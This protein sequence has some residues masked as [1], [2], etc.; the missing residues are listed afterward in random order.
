MGGPVE[1]DFGRGYERF[2]NEVI[3][4]HSTWDVYQGFFG[5]KETVETLNK[6]AGFTFWTVQ[7]TMMRDIQIHICRLLDRPEVSGKECLT[8]ERIKS[9]MPSDWSDAEKS[10]L[11]SIADE[12]KKASASIRENRNTRIAHLDLQTAVAE[13]PKG[14]GFTL[15]DI[16]S[17]IELLAKF[18][19]RIERHYGEEYHFTPINPDGPSSIE[20]HLRAGLRFYEIQ[21]A[22]ALQYITG[23]QALQKLQERP[24]RPKAEKG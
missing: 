20:C 4:L 19:N 9:L 5:S 11:H 21:K 3:E 8:A 12:L 17:V 18:M 15:G 10:D 1:D 13:G 7:T 6:V 14:L 2:R 22:Y 23:E 24:V 16:R